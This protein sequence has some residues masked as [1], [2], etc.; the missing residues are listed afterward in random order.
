M[1]NFL[2][3]AGLSL[4]LSITF[5]TAVYADIGSSLDNVKTKIDRRIKEVYKSNLD[6]KYRQQALVQL[7]N[8]ENRYNSARSLSNI[9]SQREA[10]TDMI[11]Q[12]RRELDHFDKRFNSQLIRV[13]EERKEKSHKNT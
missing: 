6:A 2:R 10:T 9:P 12:L 11:S 7:R 3:S 5:L 13:S 4:V 1:K 8:M